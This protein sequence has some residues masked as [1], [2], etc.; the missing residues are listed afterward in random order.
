MSSI[1]A[2]TSPLY[3]GEVARAPWIRPIVAVLAALA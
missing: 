3:A 1:A 2:L